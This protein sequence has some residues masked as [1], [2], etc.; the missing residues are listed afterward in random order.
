MN[1][2]FFRN[3]NEPATWRLCAQD[4]AAE[5]RA[6]DMESAYRKP[7]AAL[8]ERDAEAQ[9]AAAAEPLRNILGRMTNVQWPSNTANRRH[10]TLGQIDANVLVLACERRF[11]S[12]Q[13]AFNAKA[14]FGAPED[15]EAIDRAAQL[16]GN[17]L[18]RNT[19]LVHAAKPVLLIAGLRHEGNLETA[20]QLF[21]M[22][23]DPAYDN[24]G[25]L[26]KDVVDQGRADIGRVF[27]RYGRDGLLN[28][29]SWVNW[30]KGQRKLKLYDDL[31]RIHWEYGRFTALDNETLVETKKLPDN[32][33]AL[34]I[35]FDFAAR[36]VTEIF[37]NSNPRQ[38]SSKD[39]SFDEYGQ[40]ALEAAREKLIEMG[41]KP[42]GIELSLRGKTAV[43]RP[44]GL[45]LPGKG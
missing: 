13:D 1:E 33:G 6:I 20:E 42:S 24:N 2:D 21:K 37:E 16:A 39:F 4:I 23:A 26:F 36:R 34:K 9:R 27:A 44:A 5:L 28:V 43:A 11:L 7:S 8:T 29:E 12:W 31:R 17:T 40:N 25:E 22:G 30:A 10:Y 14:A 32:A 38:V 19:A 45:G 18:N 3:T 15:L 41:A 35:V